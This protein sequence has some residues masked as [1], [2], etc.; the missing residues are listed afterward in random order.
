MI[1]RKAKRDDVETLVTMGEKLHEV[2]KTFEPLLTFSYSDFVQHYKEELENPRALL[3]VAQDQDKVI[4][5]LYAHAQRVEYFDTDKLECE[6]EVIYVEPEYR[7]K[8]LAEKF[9]DSCLAWAE[10]KNVFRFKTGIYAQNA[11]SQAAFTKY[12][13]MPYH[14]TFVLLI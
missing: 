2:E 12:G 13:F 10:D 5:Y 14:T 4:A 8:G 1:I 9:I 6:I 3:L 7:G 11:S